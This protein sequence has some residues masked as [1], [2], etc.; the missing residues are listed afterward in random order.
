MNCANGRFSGWESGQ[1]A[2]FNDIAHLAQGEY[3]ARTVPSPLSLF[4]MPSTD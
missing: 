1:I 4:K 3:L 2:G